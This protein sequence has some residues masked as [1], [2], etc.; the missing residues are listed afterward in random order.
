MLVQSINMQYNKVQIKLQKAMRLSS[1]AV[2]LTYL[3]RLEVI[4]L[5]ESDMPII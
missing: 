2:S 1:L 3:R 5:K 4:E